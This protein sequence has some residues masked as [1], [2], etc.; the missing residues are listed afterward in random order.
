MK[1]NYKLKVCLM[2]LALSFIGNTVIATNTFKTE[3]NA[4]NSD[5]WELVKSEQG[6][7]I[8]YSNVLINGETQLKIKFQNSTNT[9][10]T[11]SWSLIKNNN[12]SLIE[13]Y[14][15]S[16]QPLNSIEFIDLTLP[17]LLNSEDSFKDFSINIKTK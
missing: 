16:I 9:Q 1:T 2:V 4:N 5:N 8:Y 11:F 12:I 15:N 14:T 10:L 7:N 13:N 17:I 3:I 6:V